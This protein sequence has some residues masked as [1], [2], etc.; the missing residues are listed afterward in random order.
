MGAA[1]TRGRPQGRPGGYDPPRRPHVPRGGPRGCRLGTAIAGFRYAGMD[2]PTFALP[3]VRLDV[4]ASLLA[5]VTAVA[6]FFRWRLE[7]TASAFWAGL[8]VFVLGCSG[9]LSTDVTR[10]YVAAGIACSVVAVGLVVVWLRGSEVDASLSVPKIVARTVAALVVVF[11][12][13]RLVVL[14][15]VAPIPLSIAIGVALVGVAIAVHVAHTRPVDGRGAGHVRHVGSR[16]RRHAG[17]GLIRRAESKRAEHGGATPAG[18]EQ[19]LALGVDHVDQ[20]LR[21]LTRKVDQRLGRR[22]RACWSPCS[23]RPSPFSRPR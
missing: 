23:L 21:E 15:D 17:A 9:F 20:D 11:A 19:A 4:G 16:L 2:T 10:G 7:G 12:G 14:H 5:S 3:V 22:A 1:Y 8:S 18:P 6:C 13:A